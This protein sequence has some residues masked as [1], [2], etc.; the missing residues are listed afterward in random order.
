MRVR[1]WLKKRQK[2]LLIE[3]ALTR[4]VL[5]GIF[6]LGLFWMRGLFPGNTRFE[7]LVLFLSLWLGSLGLAL[8]LWQPRIDLLEEDRDLGL[9]MAL[10]TLFDMEGRGSFLFEPLLRSWI[11]PRIPPAQLLRLRS[12]R[13]HLRLWISIL[14]L[15]LVLLFWLLVLPGG[16][17]G[18]I[19]EKRPGS[20]YQNTRVG[21]NPRPKNLPPKPQKHSPK[22]KL[23]HKEPRPGNRRAQP[24]PKPKEI[25]VE[26]QVVLPSFREGRGHSKREAPR[27][28]RAPEDQPHGLGAKKPQKEEGLIKKK[29]LQAKW[30]ER[31]KR[32]LERGKLS[33]FEAEWLRAWGRTLE[34]NHEQAKEQKKK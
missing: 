21:N 8:L 23:R 13:K 12:R 32:S 9:K 7:V 17:G 22:P 24:K 16:S 31:L 11:E 19:P 3:A 6:W 10:P 30:K 26:D 27:F 4:A 5:L 29:R 33:S 20:G 25:E 14:L 18:R 1:Q 2:A 34:L 15:L 28:A